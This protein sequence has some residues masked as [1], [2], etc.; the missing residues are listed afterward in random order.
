M[1]W[2]SAATSGFVPAINSPAM[3]P[4]I[5]MTPSVFNRSMVGM[6]AARMLNL[7]YSSMVCLAGMPRDNIVS[8]AVL[9]SLISLDNRSRESEQML[10]EFPNAIPA[11]GMMYW[12]CK[13]IALERARTVRATLAPARIDG[14]VTWNAWGICVARFALV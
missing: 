5:K 14:V 2:Y 4:G 9:L 11:R 12:G 6:R 10:M 8:T 3:A 1:I 7:L 13:G